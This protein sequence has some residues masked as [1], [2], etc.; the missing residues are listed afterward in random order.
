VKR[1]LHEAIGGFDE[2]VFGVEDIDYC[3]KI[4]LAGTKL[5]LVS[6]TAVYY[7]YPKKI[8]RMYSQI[9]GI[10]ENSALLYKRYL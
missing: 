8:G 5:H 2:S 3:W 7:R 6:D 1:A 9:C 4:Q 10:G